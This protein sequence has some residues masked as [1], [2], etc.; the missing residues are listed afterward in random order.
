MQRLPHA[1]TPFTS[2]HKHRRII[3]PQIF[4]FGVVVDHDVHVFGMQVHVALV[5]VLGGIKGFERNNLSDD[6][7]AEYFGAV[8][9]FT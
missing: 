9:L 2:F 4:N 1:A 8:E 7:L 3:L 6:R 5:I